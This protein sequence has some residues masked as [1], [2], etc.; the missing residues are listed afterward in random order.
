[1]KKII[2]NVLAKLNNLFRA[3]NLKIEKDKLRKFQSVINKISMIK[4]VK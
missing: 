4:F 1:M 3:D 2:P